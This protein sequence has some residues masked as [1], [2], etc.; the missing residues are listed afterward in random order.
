MA[1]FV[2]IKVIVQL[3]ILP[4]PE[5][6]PRRKEQENNQQQPKPAESN[7]KVNLSYNDLKFKASGTIGGYLE[8]LDDNY[9]VLYQIVDN[10]S[11]LI[12]DIDDFL[13]TKLADNES[14]VQ[15]VVK[16][17]GNS[18]GFFIVG[19]REAGQKTYGDLSAFLKIRMGSIAPLAIDG[20]EMR[21]MITSYED[22]EAAFAGYDIEIIK[23][24]VYIVRYKNY[25]IKAYFINNADKTGTML[26]SLYLYKGTYLDDKDDNI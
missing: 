4:E 15:I 2:L 26:W 23:D 3:I 20:R 21:T 10:E 5:L 1:V 11:I 16:N 22:F 24:N 19:Y 8:Y 18:G 7:L 6:E 25:S 17:H 14:S 13:D 12:E 9:C